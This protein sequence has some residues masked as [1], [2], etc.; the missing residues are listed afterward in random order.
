MIARIA[1]EILATPVAMH[2]HFRSDGCG[3][4][5]LVCGFV[6]LHTQGK[7]TGKSKTHAKQ[8]H[9]Q[10]CLFHRLAH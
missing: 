6:S 4:D 2:G 1:I 3:I 5:R 8:N 10:V 7:T 9:R